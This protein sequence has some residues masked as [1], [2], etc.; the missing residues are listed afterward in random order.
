MPESL[1]RLSRL[2][3]DMKIKYKLMVVLLLLIAFIC[4][5][6]VA[7]LQFIFQSYDEMLYA[8]SARTIYNSI[9]DIVRLRQE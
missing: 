1:V 2:F 3:K 6:V 4:I 9:G 7:S 5:V 8:Q